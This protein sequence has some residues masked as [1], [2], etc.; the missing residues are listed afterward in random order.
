ML[1][2]SLAEAMKLVSTEITVVLDDL[3]SSTFFASLAGAG[4]VDVEAEGPEVAVDA[5][6]A[7]APTGVAERLGSELTVKSLP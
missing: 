5:D 6:G 1:N 3:F 4:V 7:V 2:R